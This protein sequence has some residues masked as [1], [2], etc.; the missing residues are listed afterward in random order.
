MFHKKILYENHVGIPILFEASDYMGH[1]FI[2]TYDIDLKLFVTSNIIKRTNCIQTG[3][4]K[5]MDYMTSAE[6]A[7]KWNISQRRVAV[8][9]KEG[10]IEGAVLKGRMWMIPADAKSQMILKKYEI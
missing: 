8:Y 4:D 5:D 1:F 3:G 6:F 9:C 10:R 7:E 2:M